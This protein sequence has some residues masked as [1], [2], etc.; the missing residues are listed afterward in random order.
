M[1]NCTCFLTHFDRLKHSITF[2]FSLL[3]FDNLSYTYLKSSPWAQCSYD[4]AENCRV[5]PLLRGRKVPSPLC[6]CHCVN[7]VEPIPCGIESLYQMAKIDFLADA[8]PWLYMLVIT[9]TYGLPDDDINYNLLP[10]LLAYLLTYFYAILKFIIY[11]FIL[12]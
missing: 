8:F 12:V 5:S 7:S 11:F 4:I 9:M 10:Y 6:N 2:S 1:Y 3:S